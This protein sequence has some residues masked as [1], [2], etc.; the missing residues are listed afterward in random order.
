MPTPN[1]VIASD[2]LNNQP[3]SRK[4]NTMKGRSLVVIVTLL[5]SATALAQ[6][7]GF[8]RVEQYPKG[9]QIAVMSS[10]FLAGAIN[11][12]TEQ[13]VYQAPYDKVWAA[14]QRAAQALAKVGGQSVVATDE[15]SGRIQNGKISQDELVG[16]GSYQWADEFV[17][18][19]ARLT[20]SMTRVAVSRK[21]VKK[22]PNLRGEYVWQTAT[23]NGKIERWVLTL[24]ED[25]INNAGIDYAKSAPGKY[26]REKKPEDYIELK[27]DGTF[28]LH[29][30]KK[31]Y[32]GQYG[33]EGSVLTVVFGK[34]SDQAKM[35]G[36]T[37]ID[38]RGTRWVK[39]GSNTAAS[40][41]PASVNAIPAAPA[42]DTPSSEVLTNADVIRMVEAKLPDGVIVTKIKGSA[43]KFDAS[44]DALIKLR[45]A[46]AGDAVLQAIAESRCKP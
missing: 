15:Q 1:E 44:T 28:H 14:A 17:T 6:D 3:P 32:D 27:P 34:S 39:E 35:S 9:D 36:S 21:V 22:T 42:T 29:Q 43:C 26:V 31:D 45:Q 2:T 46:G 37:V 11:M 20:N 10:T 5:L 19:V 13:N 25:E 16:R 33:I 8:K 12:H 23:S 41:V 40:E 4:E 18:E 38:S 7:K 30:D 24:I